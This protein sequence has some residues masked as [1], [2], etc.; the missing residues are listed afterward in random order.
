MKGKDW[1]LQQQVHQ[2]IIKNLFNVTIVEIGDMGVEN[3][4]LR[5][6]SIGWRELSGA[7]DPPEIVEISPKSSKNK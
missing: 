6:T 4:H 2:K 3:G 1:G 5:E 7:Q